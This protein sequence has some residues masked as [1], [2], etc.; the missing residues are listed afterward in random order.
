MDSF[1]HILVPIDFDESS[2]QALEIAVVL[3]E[4]FHGALTLLHIY[5]LPV[6]MTYGAAW[7]VD[8]AQS[9]ETAARQL[10]EQSL[11]Q[12]RKRVPAQQR[13]LA[14]A[15]HGAR[16]WLKS[17]RCA[18]TQWLWAPTA[19]AAYSTSCSAVLLRK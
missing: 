7:P 8:F 4:K 14:L 12:V 2:Q 18:Q 13:S 11:N 9:A 3:S 5:D 10:L 17:M 1:H 15:S 16:F 19:V 6:Q